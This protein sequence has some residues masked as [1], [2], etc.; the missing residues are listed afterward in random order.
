MGTVAFFKSKLLKNTKSNYISSHTKNY[1][2]AHSAM[3]DYL[4]CHDE[5]Y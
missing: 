3:A 2:T 5:E 1:S 4:H